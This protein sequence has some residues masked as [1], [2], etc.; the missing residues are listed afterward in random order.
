MGG[1]VITIAILL[2]FNVSKSTLSNLLID[3]N[4]QVRRDESEISDGSRLEILIIFLMFR[5]LFWN[6]YWLY[7]YRL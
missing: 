4:S 2:S 5:Y 6:N 3:D 7:G 1:L